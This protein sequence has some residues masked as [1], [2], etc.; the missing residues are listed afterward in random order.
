[1]AKIMELDF[2]WLAVGISVFGYFIGDGLKN[3]KNPSAPNVIDMLDEDDDHQLIKEND[4]HWFIGVTKED[5]RK[6]IE[7]HPDVPH[8]RLNGN[9]YYPREKLRQWLLKIG[10]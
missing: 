4:L 9:I 6:L 10:K 3:C 5:A 7:E 8:I 2:F 1:M